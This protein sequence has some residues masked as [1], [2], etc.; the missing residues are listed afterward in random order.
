MRAHE[1]A[2]AFHRAARLVELCIR[3]LQLVDREEGAARAAG[4]A[5]PDVEAVGVAG[6]RAHHP[7]SAAAD[8]DRRVR[9]LRRLWGSDRVHDAVVPATE[10]RPLLRPKPR[11]DLARLAEP[12]APM[13][14][15]AGDL[16][17]RALPR[18]GRGLR[19]KA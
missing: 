15:G 17:G 12:H 16:P 14:A 19:P 18:R 6:G 2:R 7:G 10:R 8:P 3:L 4:A 1:S 13:A 9:S 11:A 5:P